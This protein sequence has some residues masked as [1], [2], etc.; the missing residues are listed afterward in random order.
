MIGIMATL[1]QSGEDKARESR[2]RRRAQRQGL[3]LVKSHR[4][5][6]RAADYGGYWIIDP[7]RNF[8]LA[9][10][11]NTGMELDGVEEWLDSQ[12]SLD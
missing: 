6:P 2:L 1:D 7:E 10:D 8:L 3:K 12:S 11:T 4:R 5:D 9:G